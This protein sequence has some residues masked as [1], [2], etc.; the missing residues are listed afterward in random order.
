MSRRS[1][2]DN[3]KGDAHFLKQP[4]IHDHIDAGERER[5]RYHHRLFVSFFSSSGV[6]ELFGVISATGVRWDT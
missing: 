6:G 4:V 5:L 3:D 1:R 2:T